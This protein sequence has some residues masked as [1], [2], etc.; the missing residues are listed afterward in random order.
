MSWK[1]FR[2][3]RGARNYRNLIGS[4]RPSNPNPQ[5]PGVDEL[6]YGPSFNQLNQ[7]N[8]V[9]AHDSG[10]SGAGVLL[11]ARYGFFLEHEALVD[12]PVLAQWDFI[13]NDSV[14]QNSRGR[15]SQ[16]NHGTYT[17]STL[18]GAHDGQLYG[19]LTARPS[20]RKTE[21]IDFEQPVEEDWYI[22]GLEWADSLGAQVISTSLGYFDW[23]TFADLDGNTC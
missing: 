23:Y 22:A 5:P 4:A 2:V 17:F 21:S 6:N 1:C 12:Q 8:V 3:A 9:A 18:G 7:I 20:S 14:T 15:S 16:H 10:Y 19:R 11:P 13:N